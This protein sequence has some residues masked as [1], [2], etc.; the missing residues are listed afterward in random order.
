MIKARTSTARQLSSGDN[1]GL[2]IDGPKL[3]LF[4]EAS[5]RAIR[6][7]LYDGGLTG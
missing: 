6:S 5:G 3:S 2:K 4:E 7:V 1:V